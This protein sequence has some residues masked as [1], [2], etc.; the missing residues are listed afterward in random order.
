MCITEGLVL[1]GNAFNGSI[2]MRFSKMTKL[3]YIDLSWNNFTGNFPD[4]SLVSRLKFLYLNNNQLLGPLDANLGNLTHLQEVWLQSNRFTGSIPNEWSQLS[5]LTA[6]LLQDTDLNGTVP[7]GI[8]NLTLVQ[9]EADCN[10]TTVTDG[11][12]TS[13]GDDNETSG[14]DGIFVECSCCTVCH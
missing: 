7:E 4:L 5:N 6:L 11:N 1:Y 14:G 8:C 10:E 2:E 13:V 12:E 9:L 3:Y